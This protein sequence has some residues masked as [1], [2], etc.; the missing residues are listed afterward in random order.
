MEVPGHRQSALRAGAHGFH[1]GDPRRQAVQ[2]TEDGGR[3]HADGNHG[4][5]VRLQRQGGHLGAGAQLAGGADAGGA[6]ARPAADPA[7]AHARTN[8]DRVRYA[9]LA[10]L[11]AAAATPAATLQRF[12]F[13]EPH[14]GTLVR[15]VLYA[16]DET[17]ATA[18]SKAAFA[19]IAALDE[20]L[21]DYRETS[22]VTRLSRA[23]PG[24]AVPVSDEL[25]RVLRASQAMARASEGA[26]DV[27]AGPL[28][29][30]WRA[31]RRHHEAPDSDALDEAR[32]RVGFERLH[33]DEQRRT[34][35]LR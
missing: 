5:H 22:E 24:Q 14:M 6:D 1:R 32:A 18:A 29:V 3:E 2:R 11:I 17:N 16:V 12:E 35:T 13:S 4:P 34:V 9:T 28:T 31:A 25:L 8:A 15:I 7:R 23:A 21:S 10:L 30:L 26:F 20:M 27:T 19:R 33:L